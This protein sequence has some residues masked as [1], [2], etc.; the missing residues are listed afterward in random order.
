[1]KES[2]LKVPN[3]L[4]KISP[5]GIAIEKPINGTT[6][7]SLDLVVADSQSNFGQGSYT[8]VQLK[9]GINLSI[10]YVKEDKTLTLNAKLNDAYVLQAINGLTIFDVVES[11]N[12]LATAEEDT[13]GQALN[14]KLGKVDAVTELYGETYHIAFSSK[15]VKPLDIKL[16]YVLSS[17]TT[18]DIFLN[19]YA[20]GIEG[21]MI[22]QDNGTDIGLVIMPDPHSATDSASALLL[23]GG[24]P[25]IV[26]VA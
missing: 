7:T 2:T 5:L 12:I 21:S 1:M 8:P 24:Q 17:D 16:S 23:T 19:F 6:S 9:S 26:S 13:A 22:K 11:K 14:V 4:I 25:T 3:D 15:G 18:T 10:D 20:G